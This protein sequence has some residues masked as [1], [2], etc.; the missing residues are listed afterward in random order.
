MSDA[1]IDGDD[2]DDSDGDAATR[3][4]AD[5][6]LVEVV[7]ATGHEHVT[8]EHASTVE[9]TTDDWLT[10]AGDCIVGVEAD[11]TP[12]DFSPEFR[13]ACRDANATIT[14]TI[15]VGEPG[16]ADVSLDDPAHVDAI[17][18]R[19]D[20]G[21][22]L[23]DDRSMVGRTSDYTDD[24]RTIFV[25]GDGAAADLDRDLVAALAEGAPTALRLEVDPA[26]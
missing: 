23:V 14:A 13:E 17:V 11:R 4:G 2:S 16:A 6:A 8:A 26:E 7:R 10:P 5:D 25:E 9:F 18:G 24:E 19:G 3:P 20:P 12:R 15:A 21:L 1:E 22:A